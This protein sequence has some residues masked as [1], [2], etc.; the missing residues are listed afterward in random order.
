[1]YNPNFSG[2]WQWSDGSKVDYTYWSSQSSTYQFAYT[3]TNANSAYNWY[4]AN[5]Y[6][7]AAMCQKPANVI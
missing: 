5:E 3:Q 6:D 2:N 7:Y 4:P 1:M